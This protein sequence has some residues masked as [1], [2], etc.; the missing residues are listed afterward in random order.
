MLTTQSEAS[1][2]ERIKRARADIIQDA[3]REQNTADAIESEQSEVDQAKTGQANEQSKAKSKAE[4]DTIEDAEQEPTE[5]DNIEE[6]EA[7]ESEDLESDTLEDDL[8][9]SGESDELYLEL[10]G[11]EIP[12]SQ[13]KE[14]KNGYL[15]QSDYAKRTQQLAQERKII[16]SQKQEY[17]SKLA[18]VQE[19]EAELLA[20]SETEQYS[21]EELAEL[22]EYDPERYIEVKEKQEKRQKALEKAKGVKKPSF[23]VEAEQQKLFKANPQWFDNGKPTAEYQKDMKLLEEYAVKKGF[24]QEDFANFRSAHFIALLEAA[25]F[26]SQKTKSDKVLSKV[27]KTPLTTKPK[28]KVAQKDDTLE[29]LKERF[30]KSGKIEDAAAIRKYLKSKH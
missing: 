11:E 29:K 23:D 5:D 12:L 15:R 7:D 26:D 30:Q 13:V 20:L 10:D 24:T 27:K 25:R 19:L 3:P 17:E 6:V 16:E 21:D 14:W 18:K 8:D 28:G 1:I 4:I 9:N 22:K 2:L